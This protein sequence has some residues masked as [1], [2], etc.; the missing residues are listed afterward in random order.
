MVV[1]NDKDLMQ[2]V[3]PRVTFY[4]AA[5]DRRLIQQEVAAHGGCILYKSP[6]Y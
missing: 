3:T 6:I 5:K 4:D 1:S 2:L